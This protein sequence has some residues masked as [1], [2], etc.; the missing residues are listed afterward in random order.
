LQYLNIINSDE[1]SNLKIISFFKII[2]F[3][4]AA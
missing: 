2:R 3:I 1:K 4:L